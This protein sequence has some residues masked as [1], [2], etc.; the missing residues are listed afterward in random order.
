VERIAYLIATGFYSG[1]GPRI[2]GQ[3]VG[4]T[5]G[6]L[7]ALLFCIFFLWMNNPRDYAAATILI[8]AA[9]LLSVPLAE[10]A[11]GP[12]ENH[13][14]IIVRRDQN[15]ITIDEWLGIFIS[16][17]PVMYMTPSWWM[18]VPA[19]VG[20]IGFRI[21]DTRK[22]PVVRYFDRMKSSCGVMLD[23][24]AAGTCTIPF[25]AAATVLTSAVIS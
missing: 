1:R 14:G 18:A 23:D 4:G 6:S 24:F 13:K 12:E 19:S 22:P 2:K 7:A 3:A 15:S 17:A 21:F 9:G 11:I 10:K 16:L 8:F 5:Y 25:T 20:F